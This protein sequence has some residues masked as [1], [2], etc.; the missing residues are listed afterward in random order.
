MRRFPCRTVLVVL[1]FATPCLR[2]DATFM[3]NTVL[4]APDVASDGVCSTP[5]QTCSLR[6][7]I[8]EA[9]A[10]SGASLILL[11]AGTYP[12]VVPGTGGAEVGDLDVTKPME[13]RG[14]GA[15]TTII[16]A[17]S[18]GDRIFH[19]LTAGA[20]VISGVTMKK[21]SVPGDGGC[22]RHLD[23]YLQLSRTV[24]SDC[25]ASR[26]GGIYSVSSLG[27]SATDTTFE[28]NNTDGPGGAL[29]LGGP[30]TFDVAR[31]LFRENVASGL[32]GEGGAIALG[33]APFVN[34]VNTTFE[35]NH[36]SNTGG[37]VGWEPSSTAFVKLY[38]VTV[39]GNNAASGGAFYKTGGFLYI[40]NSVFSGNIDSGGGS[41]CIGTFNSYVYNRFAVP[42]AAGRRCLFRAG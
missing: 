35:S 30:G 5:A 20:F 40:R 2:G 25:H 33:G 18:L 9:N 16:D 14:A 11:P 42:A 27:F 21:G 31:C 7:A 10:V 1:A 36:T 41:D 28:L 37:A 4:D 13:I 32:T 23:G 8:Q 3:V 34:V 24:V 26:G 38:N 15:G 29:L 17:A 22:I 6:A 19:V 12:L 39:A